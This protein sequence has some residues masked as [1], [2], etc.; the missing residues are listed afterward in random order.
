M[1][2]QLAIT[3]IAQSPK[4]RL[5]APRQKALVLWLNSAFGILAFFSRRVTTEGAF[6]PMKKPAWESMPV[7]NV[8]GLSA[9]QTTALA[10]AYDNV[11][12]KALAPLAQLDADSVR[13]EIDD[14]ICTALRLLT[15][16][17]ELTGRRI[18]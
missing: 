9:A 17:P 13:Y 12:P 1:N 6:V 11:A 16:E 14:A 10:D 8:R 5:L 18:G 7:L 3:R 15:R 4:A 2:T